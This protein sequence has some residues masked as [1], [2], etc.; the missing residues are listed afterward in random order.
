[1][2][3]RRFEIVSDED[4]GEAGTKTIDLPTP[5][6]ITAIDI[7]GGFLNVTAGSDE[8]PAANFKKIEVVDGSDVLYSLTGMCGQAVAFY[9]GVKALYNH[10]E[11]A[12]GAYQECVIP[13]RFGRFLRDPVL[14]LDTKQF[15]A[16]QLKVTWDEDLAE[17][18]CASHSITIY[19][20]VFD[21]K[22]ISPIGFLMNKEHYSYS[23]AANAYETLEL[24][25]DY[26]MRRF[27]VQV[28]VPGTD[29][30]NLLS[31]VRLDEDF[32]KRIPIEEGLSDMSIRH[33]LDYPLLHES[34]I[35]Y[36]G[37]TAATF[38]V[39]CDRYT[40]PVLMNSNPNPDEALYARYVTGC[41]ISL[42]TETSTLLCTL[43][44]DGMFPHAVCDFPLGDQMD[45][46]DWLDVTK[47]ESARLRIKAGASAGDA[48]TFRVL[49]QQLRRY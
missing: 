34:Y 6:P 21:Q 41:Q 37:P 7:K 13:I 18:D 12:A 32:M 43:N 33:Q 15:T 40:N 1:M 19:V 25:R 5:D 47:L 35:V 23:P 48:Y 36:P 16:P 3:Y 22:A 46:D 2:N 45:I 38:Y 31:N 44:I 9:D 20:T 49:T 42:E 24:P 8:H 29:M 11:N 17:T 39:T 14:A 26:P 30:A 28:R 27:A 10:I 4:W